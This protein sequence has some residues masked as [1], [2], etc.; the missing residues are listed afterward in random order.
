[1]KSNLVFT[2][3]LVVVLLTACEK[4]DGAEDV[5]IPNTPK[6]EVPN[7]LTGKW[8]NGT[9]AMSNWWSYDGKQYLG[10]PYTRSTAFSFQKNGDMEF[11]QVIKTFTGTCSTEGFTTYKGTVKFD[12]ANQSFTMYPQSGNFRGFY[13]CASGSNFNRP[14]KKEE[15]K[16][17][18]FY[19]STETDSN[20][21]KWMVIK[22]DQQAS[23]QGTYFKP[24]NW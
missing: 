8:Q 17:T 9:F 12:H 11:F 13:S 10:N 5:L 21:Q 20:G 14:V 1:M 3:F 15:L 23:S 22:F 19:W 16:P 6:S 4:T 24:A 18:T 2:A 7:E